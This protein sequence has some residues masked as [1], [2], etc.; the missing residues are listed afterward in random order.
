MKEPRL[1]VWNRGTKPAFP[2]ESVDTG[3]DYV[4]VVTETANEDGFVLVTTHKLRPSKTMED[5][6]FTVLPSA[7]WLVATADPERTVRR[8]V[9]G[10]EPWQ[11]TE[12]DTPTGRRQGLASSHDDLAVGIWDLDTIAISVVGPVRL[13]SNG[14]SVRAISFPVNL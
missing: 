14:F 5:V 12:L 2:G 13:L 9:A 6:L 3:I 11:T 10:A 4:A 7:P 1:D 8:I